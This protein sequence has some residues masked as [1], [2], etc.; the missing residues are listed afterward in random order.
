MSAKDKKGEIA[1]TLAALG[2]RDIT[3]L[4]LRLEVKS[5]RLSEWKSKGIPAKWILHIFKEY[6]VSPN[7]IIYNKGYP[8]C[9]NGYH[10][11]YVRISGL[12]ITEQL[13]RIC[14][15]FPK[16][17]RRGILT[18]LNFHPSTFNYA[19]KSGHL[20]PLFLIT[21]FTVYGISPT[22]VTNGKKPALLSDHAILF[23][24]AQGLHFTHKGDP[25]DQ[26]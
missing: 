11:T 9:T 3:H 17:T 25:Y 26:A 12:K 6:N 18:K 13:K 5:S 1:R 23:F 7:W 20:T 4:A 2:M 19:L 14:V 15:L 8:K 22:W 21:L 24:K 16:L 10:P